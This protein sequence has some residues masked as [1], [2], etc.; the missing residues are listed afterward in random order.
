[1]IF[2]QAMDEMEERVRE[3]KKKEDFD[4]IRPDLDGNEIMELLGLEP[5]PDD[6]PRL[7]AHAGIPL[8]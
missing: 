5:G 2:S 3:L 1:M 8:G 7:Q 4:A 6:R